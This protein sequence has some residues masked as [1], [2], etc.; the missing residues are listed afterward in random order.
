MA[1]AAVIGQHEAMAVPGI[2]EPL[3]AAQGAADSAREA[4]AAAVLRSLTRPGSVPPDEQHRLITAERQAEQACAE[5]PLLHRTAAWEPSGDRRR[6]PLVPAQRPV[7]DGAVAGGQLHA[8]PGDPVQVT[9]DR[10]C[11]VGVRALGV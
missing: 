9:V 5:H 6:L 7:V 11:E 10:R 2:V 3:T 4:L 8:G 1:A